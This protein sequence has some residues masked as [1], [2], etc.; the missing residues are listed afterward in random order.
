MRISQTISVVNV[1]EPSSWRLFDTEVALT[2][3]L[4]YFILHDSNI[5]NTPK[6]DHVVNL[7]IKAASHVGLSATVKLCLL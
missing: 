6:S 2:T 7:Q 4:V 5:L 1:A 3:C